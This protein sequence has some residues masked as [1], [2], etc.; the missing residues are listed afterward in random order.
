MW[1][2]FWIVRWPKQ[3][4]SLNSAPLAAPGRSN[5]TTEPGYRVTRDDFLGYSAAIAPDDLESAISKMVE[6]TPPAN[7][8]L[9]KLAYGIAAGLLREAGR[10]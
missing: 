6:L 1:R 3:L 5:D 10:L 4:R 7:C 9:E 2:L 8:L